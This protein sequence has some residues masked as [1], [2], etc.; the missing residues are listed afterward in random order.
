MA[1]HNLNEK[2]IPLTSY[3]SVPIAP[4]PSQPQNPVYYAQPIAQPVAGGQ[5]PPY[6]QPP[7][8]YQPVYSQPGPVMYAQAPQMY[9]AAPAYQP[10]YA[11]PTTVAQPAP[12]A[13]MN[14][15]D[16]KTALRA[17][18]GDFSCKRYIKQ[19][20]QFTRKNW[21]KLFMA[22]V[23]W[24][25]VGWGVNCAILKITKGA[26][27]SD[28]HHGEWR[29]PD[30]GDQIFTGCEGQLQEDKMNCGGLGCFK[31]KCEK[32][33]SFSA[34]QSLG[35][36]CWCVDEQG[37]KF[38]DTVTACATFTTDC[39]VRRSL[40]SCQAQKAKDTANCAGKMGCF[41]T[42][43]NAYG[44]FQPKQYR[45]GGCWCVDSLG[46][47]LNGT[48]A[49]CSH[50]TVCSEQSQPWTNVGSAYYIP[51][52][53]PGLRYFVVW[54]LLQLLV[55][56]VLW[57]PV[58]GGFYLAVFNAIKSNSTICF[59][60]FFRCFCCRY[61][62]R[63]LALS[64]FLRLFQSLLFLLIVPGIWWSLATMFAIPLHKEHSF[65]GVCG[66]IR[67]SMVAIHRHFCSM[68]CF[69][70]LLALMQ[71]A[72]FLCLIVGVLYT[73]PLA[74]VALCYCYHDIIGIVIEAPFAAPLDTPVM[75]HV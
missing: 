14:Y 37:S 7:Q 53:Y 44:D 34:K 17:R 74:F 57:G 8:M 66:S 18:P 43:C 67:M 27:V 22:M 48:R 28:W 4:P 21:C 52:H 24:S 1:Y 19:A 9:A 45:D 20:H 3:P 68:F 36:Q 75:V 33:G 61:Y 63:L 70:L 11:N 16:L 56:I 31:T 40:S 10:V 72:G 25:L 41:V 30:G 60:D 42:Q 50:D 47:E 39:A 73:M 46:Q 38:A 59:R 2:N 35:S 71:I 12:S 69:L 26:G 49:H 65:L 55:S 51:S 64:F 62:C 5:Q 32:D 29:Y 58:I 54:G 23:V 15:Q 13:P 6:A